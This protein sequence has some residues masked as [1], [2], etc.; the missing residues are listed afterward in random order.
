MRITQFAAVISSIEWRKSRV[1][2]RERKKTQTHRHTSKN[3]L[4]EAPTEYRI[5]EK[6]FHTDK[7]KAT[8]YSNWIREKSHVVQ[9]WSD[10]LNATRCLRKAM[11]LWLVKYCYFTQNSAHA[12]AILFVDL[13]NET[14]LPDRNEQRMNE[15]KTRWAPNTQH[16]ERDRAEKRRDNAT[17][18]E[19]KEEEE[20][21]NRSANTWDDATMKNEWRTFAESVNSPV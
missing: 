12:D 1:R 21:M 10:K 5:A 20:K 11:K 16:R 9:C 4:V 13:I 8:E 2:E 19:K 14:N 18:R 17:E 7:T 3:G 15:K 6:K